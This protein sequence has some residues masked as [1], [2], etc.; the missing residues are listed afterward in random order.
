MRFTTRPEILGTLGVCTSTH[1][2]ASTT[3]MGVLERGGNAFDAAIATAFVLQVVEPHLVGPAGEVP[4]IFHSART[5]RTEVLCGQGTAPAAATVQAFRDMGLDMVPGSGFLPAVVPGSFDAWMVLLR[6]HGTWSV[7]DALAPALHYAANGHPLLPRVANTLADI[8]DYF[9]EHWPTSAE[10]FLPGGQAP[11]PHALFRNP[12]LAATWERIIAEAEARPGRE[13]QI[14]AARDAWYRGFV[15]EAIGRFCET[16]AMDVTGTPHRGLL[17]ADDMANWQATYEEPASLDYG[18]WTV[19]KTG[20]WGQGPAFLQALAILRGVDIASMD[21]AGPEFV[22][23]VT[24]AIKLAFAD[25]EAYYGDPAFAEVPLGTLLSEAYAADRRALIADTASVQHRPGVLPGFEAQAAAAVARAARYTAGAQA[26]GAGEPTNA[27]LTERRGDTVHIDVIDRWGNMVSATPSG[28]W[29]QSSPVVPGLGFPLNTR[30]QMFWLDEGL[31]TTLRPGARPRTTLTPSLAH[32]RGRPALVFGTPGGD[33]QD[34]WQLPM[35]LRHVHHGMNLQEAIDMPLFHTAHVQSSFW[36][37]DCRPGHLLIEPAAGEAAIA[38]LR[39]KGHA[40]E[41]SEPWAIGR[42]TAAG[43]DENGLLRA[44]ATPRL[45][46]A[47][48]VGR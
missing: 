19:F 36:P 12:A 8:A 34:Q 21:P 31:P 14:E 10:T 5:G 24:E 22:H 25:R 48:A 27:H 11:A 18:E 28:G 39:A 30:G 32:H 15:A 2:L 35:F 40:V 1:W 7:R 20:P 43:R 47:Y 6:D 37:R 26:P 3:G 33:Q 41:V 16:E 17:T 13:A 44:A 42:L 29:F 45:M 46:Q 38:A 9:R 23:V 4:V